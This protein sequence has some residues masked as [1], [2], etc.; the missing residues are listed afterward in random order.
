VAEVVIKTMELLQFK[1]VGA[2]AGIESSGF[3]LG[4]SI[5]K[6]LGVPFIM[7]RKAGKL[8][9]PTFNES[10][11]LEYGE[12][13]IEI[14]RDVLLPNMCTAILDNVLATGGTA[15]AAAKLIRKQVRNR[16]LLASLQ[17]SAFYLEGNF[18][19]K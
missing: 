9:G 6:K 2:I 8:L 1:D 13:S 12:A 5:A 15:V 17:N 18:C 7:I 11:K 4:V 10:Y 19:K 16:F 14:H 3:L